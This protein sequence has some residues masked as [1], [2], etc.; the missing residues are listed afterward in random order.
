[1]KFL[2]FVLLIGLCILGYAF[3]LPPATIENPDIKINLA[4]GG[5][6]TIFLSLAGIMGGGK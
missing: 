5:L 2:P 4:V 3:T 1:M 6:F